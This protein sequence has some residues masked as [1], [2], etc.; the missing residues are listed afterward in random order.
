[1][2]LDKVYDTWRSTHPLR[3]EIGKSNLQFGLTSVAVTIFK[4]TFLFH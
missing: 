2:S 3:Q 1:M 4:F